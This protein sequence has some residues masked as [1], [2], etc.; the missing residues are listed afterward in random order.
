MNANI[1]N[2]GTNHFCS[3]C[4]AL[5]KSDDDSCWKCKA[6]FEEIVFDEVQEVLGATMTPKEEIV[7]RFKYA[8][9]FKRFAAFII[10]LFILFLAN[11]GF[12]K[13]VS[14]SGNSADTLSYSSGY[15]ISLT[16]ILLVWLYFSVME[17]S[18]K[19]GTI[20]KILLGIKVVDLEGDKISFVRAVLRHL[21]KSLSIITIGIGFIMIGFTKEKQGLHD[22]TSKCLVISE[23]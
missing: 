10:D 11:V 23:K 14:V 21:S 4:E 2:R 19:Q 17:S 13:Y 6:V 12:G 5:V 8:G 1:I 3:N 7:S 20:G 9:F 15:S 18:K 16:G 22:I